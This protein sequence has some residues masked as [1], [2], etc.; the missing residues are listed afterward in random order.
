MGY[1]KIKF[2]S[3]KPELSKGMYWGVFAIGLIACAV[4]LFFMSPWFWTALPFLFTGL[5]GALDAM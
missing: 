4:F 5:T 2:M 3:E 1:Q